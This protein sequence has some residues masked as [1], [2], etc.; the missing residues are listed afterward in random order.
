MLTGGT[1]MVGRNILE[2]PRSANFEIFAPAREKLDLFD[3]DNVCANLKRFRPD[4]VVHCAGRVGGIHA[5]IANPTAFLVENVDMGRNIVLAS[6][7]A[8]VERLITLG[9]TC[10]Y[11]RNIDRPI[12]EEEILRG[13]LEPTN[14]AYAIAKCFVSRLCTYISRENPELHYK[15]LIPSNL[16]GRW[17]NFSSHGAHMLPSI[18]RKL[19][20]AKVTGVDSIEIWGDGAARRE[21]LYAG[22]AAECILRAVEKFDSLPDVMNIG[23]GFD[24]SVNEYYEIAADVLGFKGTFRHDLSKPVGMARKLADI[25]RQKAWGWEARTTLRDGIATTY[26]FYI[27]HIGDRS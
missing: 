21:F 15:T 18:I 26:K 7:E 23:L 2:H 9:S 12:P 27:D 13:E 3:Y 19:H 14:E 16:Y 1:G 8:G 20:E 22:D 17:D 25:S 10:M 24:Y 11:P 5:N 4:V 6:K